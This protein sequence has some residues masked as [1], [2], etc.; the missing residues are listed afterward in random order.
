[1]KDLAFECPLALMR[2]TNPAPLAANS[3]ANSAPAHMPGKP[4]NKINS[5]LRI[6]PF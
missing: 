4:S 3:A 1:M 6:A 2:M 5:R